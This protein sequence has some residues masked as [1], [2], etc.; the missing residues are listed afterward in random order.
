MVDLDAHQ[1]PPDLLRNVYK[2]YTRR[3][4]RTCIDDDAQV[5]DLAT[6]LDSE[7][8]KSFVKINFGVSRDDLSRAFSS[9]L[10]ETAD[11]HAS[12]QFEDEAF[13]SRE[14]DGMLTNDASVS[15]LIASR[16][17][18]H[19]KSHTTASAIHSALTHVP[20]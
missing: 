15:M 7:Q 14:I 13:R 9:F 2:E 6:G 17:H 10:A 20:S 1:R 11:E 3:D 8:E 16:T 19:T 5:V 12:W 18:C 4:R